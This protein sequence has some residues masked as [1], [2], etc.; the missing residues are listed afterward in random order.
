MFCVSL[1]RLYCQEVH[2]YKSLRDGTV[3]FL[4]DIFEGEV[5]QRLFGYHKW[6]PSTVA[7]LKQLNP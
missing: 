7:V 6:R 1:T 2:A 3:V 5:G 4:F